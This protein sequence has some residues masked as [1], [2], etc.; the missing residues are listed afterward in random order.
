M[1]SK[2]IHW[3]ILIAVIVLAAILRFWDLTGNPPGLNWDEVSHSYNAYSLLKTGRDQWGQAFPFP[4]FRA[5]GDYPTVLNLY[6]TVPAVAILGPTD[7]AA[8]FPHALLGVLSCLLIFTA[9]YYWSKHKCL[10]LFA[11]FLYAVSP[12]TLFPS[13]AVFQSNWSVFLLTLGLALYFS[14]HKLHSLWIFMLSLLAYHNTRIFIPMIL[15]FVVYPLRKNLQQLTAGILVFLLSVIL[16]LSPEVRARNSWVGIVDS[17]AIAYLEQ[18]RNL[19]KLTPELSRL[20]YNRPVYFVSKLAKN[21]FGYFSPQF[22]FF[23]GGTQ[24]QFS[25]PGFGLINPVLAPFFYLGVIVFIKRRQYLLLAWLVLSPL[26]AAI[27]RDPYA[28]IRSTTMLP[29]IVLA[30][31]AGLL[32]VSGFLKRRWHTLFWSTFLVLFSLS[33]YYY[34]YFK[35]YPR[36]FSRDW[37]YGYKQL[38]EY[39][40]PKFSEYD[41]IV[42]TKYYAEPHEY[43]LWY[44]PWDPAAYLQDKMLSTSF[45]SDWYWVDRFSKFEFINDWEMAEYVENISPEEKVL[46][47]TSPGTPTLGRDVAKINFLNGKTAF[48][49]KDI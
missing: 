40:K 46:V 41:R 23:K 14:R 29:V 44:W 34:S 3:L 11:A 22:L 21:Y 48:I 27:T 20:I 35:D 8:R 30:V 38:V 9:A 42:I 47:I 25:V 2:K 10:S 39:I 24:Y 6:M 17:G 4:N 16:L 36:D 18:S 33:G 31:S 15:P 43:V 13:R 32:Y 37:Q 26:P 49:I 19:S 1:V 45:H 28:V 5:Y 7:F 12:W